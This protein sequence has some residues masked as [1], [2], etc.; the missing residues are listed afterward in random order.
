MKLRLSRSS[1]RFCPMADGCASKIK[2]DTAILTV[3]YV[4]HL[5]TI[6]NH[7]NQTVAQHIAKLSSE[8]WKLKHLRLA[9]TSDQNRKIICSKDSLQ[10]DCSLVCFLMKDSMVPMEPTPSSSNISIA[11]NWM[12]LGVDTVSTAN[13][14]T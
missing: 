13:P 5:P 2:F 1:P 6:A 14:S 3:L 11:V 4:Q 7:L 8:E 10:N 12:Y 9:K